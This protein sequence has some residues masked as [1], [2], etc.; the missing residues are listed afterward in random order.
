MGQSGAHPGFQAGRARYTHN[1]R[2]AELAPFFPVK[3]LSRY[4]ALSA[5]PE[6]YHAIPT[7]YE[8]NTT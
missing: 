5:I 7:Q 6:R 3:R 1:F 8:R 4:R 2:C